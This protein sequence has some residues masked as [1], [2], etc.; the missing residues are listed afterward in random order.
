MAVGVWLAFG[1]HAPANEYPNRPVRILIAFAAA[2]NIDMLG[3]II[4]QKLGDMWGQSVFVENRP[5]ASGNIGAQAAA[6]AA[7]DGSTLHFG[8]QTLAVNVT[9]VADRRVRSGHGLRADHA[10]CDRAG[11]LAGRRRNAVPLGA[12]GDRLRQG[13]SR[14]AELRLGRHRLERPSRQRCSATCRRN[15]AARAATASCRDAT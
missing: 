8:A 12:G 9:L 2:G 11:G 14:Q 4:A 10:G 1:A 5:G 15:D 13:P 3:R 7:P 6:Q